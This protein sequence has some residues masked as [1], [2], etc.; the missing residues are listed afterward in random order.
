LGGRLADAVQASCINP[1]GMGRLV[2]DS[3][4]TRGGCTRI[5][6]RS[7][8]CTSRPIRKSD[9][10]NLK[11]G[12]LNEQ[13]YWIIQLPY[14]WCP[15]ES[16]ELYQPSILKILPARQPLLVPHWLWPPPPCIVAILIPTSPIYQPSTSRVTIQQATRLYIPVTN[17]SALTASPESLHI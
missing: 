10:S 7:G 3:W 14:D 16:A 12:Q 8:P 5:A 15:L 1:V 4:A 9:T 11:G 17:L 13:P 6:T 2:G